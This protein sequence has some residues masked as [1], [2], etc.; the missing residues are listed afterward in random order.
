M[1]RPDFPMAMGVIRSA[2]STVYEDM[3]HEQIVHA[4]RESKIKNMDDLLVS[5]NTFRI[6]K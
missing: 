3:L 4:K 5:G 1:G 2:E 6:D